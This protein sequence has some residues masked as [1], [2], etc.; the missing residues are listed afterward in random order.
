MTVS[1]QREGEGHDR[2]DARVFY[3]RWTG[4]SCYRKGQ[5]ARGWGGG[6]VRGEGRDLRRLV[7]SYCGAL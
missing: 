4:G 1:P 5:E 7:A 6:S 2:S 3:P